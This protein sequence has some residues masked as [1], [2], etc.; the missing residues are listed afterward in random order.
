MP[1]TALIGIVLALLVGCSQPNVKR[2]FIKPGPSDLGAVLPPPPTLDSAEGQAEID[3]IL[4]LQETRSPAD[5]ERVKSE[6]E[7]DVFAFATV[8]GSHFNAKECPKSAEVFAKVVAEARLVSNA[9]K[10]QW[11]R[12]R[13]TADPRVH[14]LDSEKSFS[15][16]SGHSTRASV[17]A[18]LLAAAVPTKRES[19]LARGREIGWDRVIAGIHFPTDVYGGRVLGHAIAQSMLRDPDLRRELDEVADEIRRV[20]GTDAPK[21]RLTPSTIPATPATAPALAPTTDH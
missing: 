1:R 18:E 9:S 13:P 2:P 17:Y 7:Y 21:F 16:P 20:C 15:Y 6:I 10:R 19:L 14:A 12:P 11:E 8:L 4:R 5:V 3:L